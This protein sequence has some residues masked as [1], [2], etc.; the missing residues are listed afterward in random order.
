GGGSALDTAAMVGANAQALLAELV[1]RR[2]RHEEAERL[3]TQALDAYTRH[4]GTDHPTTARC[5]CD[6][7][8]VMARR[9]RTSQG[10]HMA[11]R[12]LAAATAAHGE[13]HPAVAACWVALGDNLIAKGDNFE[14]HSVYRTAY[15]II[16]TAN[17][18]EDEEALRV[19]R[20]IS[21]LDQEL[22]W[23]QPEEGNEG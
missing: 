10:E 17:G 14:A 15:D 7:A 23:G 3:Y 8:A 21:Q 19:D 12:A 2:G 1:T 18:Q 20:L 22:G 11:R 13:G 5:M 16:A 6:L 9:G 4:Y